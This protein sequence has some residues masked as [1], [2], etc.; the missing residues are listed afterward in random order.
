[1]NVDNATKTVSIDTH[2]DHAVTQRSKGI[3]YG[4]GRI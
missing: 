4:K 3:Y 2:G 1:M